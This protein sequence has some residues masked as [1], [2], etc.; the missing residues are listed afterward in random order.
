M[1]VTAARRSRQLVD[2][3]G[4]ACSRSSV[5]HTRRVFNNVMDIEMMQP[6]TCSH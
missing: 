2:C 1:L 5:L 6:H 3:V 4:A